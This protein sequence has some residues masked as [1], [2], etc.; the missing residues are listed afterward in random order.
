MPGNP[1]KLALLI[2]ADNVDPKFYPEIMESLGA[3][4]TVVVRRAYGNPRTWNKKTLRDATLKH[5]L[6]S[7]LVVPPIETKDAADM[8]LAIDAVDLIHAG[9]LDGIAIASSDSDFAI[10]AAR[11][12]ESGIAVY[13][14][15]ET[16]T[17]EAFRAACTNFTI[18]LQPSARKA[19]APAPR[20]ASSGKPAAPAQRPAPAPA[21]AK[22]PAKPA[23]RAFPIDAVLEAFDQS[24]HDDGWAPLSDLGRS[25]AKELP[26]FRPGDY[27]ADRLATFLKLY[28]RFE[29]NEKGDA[30]RLR[31][32]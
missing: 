20:A 28:P 3:L 22:A 30:V 10:L 16:K 9:R 12:A 24:A 27:G 2:D 8:R 25:L 13:G 21:R 7:V 26:G 14:F 32:S 1:A 17:P 4:G 29:F 31:R 23:A 15:G 19:A 6:T 18:L 5:G 11:I